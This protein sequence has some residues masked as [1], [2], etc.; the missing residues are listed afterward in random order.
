MAKKANA[1]WPQQSPINICP[2][3]TFRAQFAKG[4]L[5]IKYPE[6]FRGG[7]TECEVDTH[8][9]QFTPEAGT[10]P[11]IVFDGQDCPL[12]KLHFHTP[13]EHQIDGKTFPLEIHFVHEIPNPERGSQ[14]VVIGVFLRKVAKTVTS[15]GV[16]AFGKYWA[17][18]TANPEK[19]ESSIDFQ[20]YHFLPSPMKSG[21]YA[22][23]RYEGG[24]TTPAYAE[25][26]SWIVMRDIV[27]VGAADLE[28]IVKNSD[29]PAREPQPLNRRF[30][31]RNFDLGAAR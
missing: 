7:F 9:C 18:L 6:K 11:S 3:Q 13:S 27:D 5:G 4:Y 19:A 28:R 17:K 25:T 10:S 24:L 20:P 2:S 1:V 12:K 21:E 31:L 26:V 23:Y 16:K 15:E 29:H 8:E 22:F 14:F 30:V